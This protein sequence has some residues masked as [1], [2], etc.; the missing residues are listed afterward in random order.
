[1]KKKINMLKSAFLFACILSLICV[2]MTA[3]GAISAKKAPKIN[4]FTANEMNISLGDTVILTWDVEDATSIE[5]LGLEKEQEE[6]LEAKGSLEAWPMATTTYVLIATGEGGTSST[7]LTVNVDVAGDVSLEYFNASDIAVVIGDTV[8]LSWKTS[9]AKEV[10]IIGLE[11]TQEEGLPLCGSIETWPM[12]TTTYVIRVTGKNDEVVSAAI[13]VNIVESLPAVINSFTASKE[14]INEGEIVKLEWDVADAVSVTINSS[15]VKANGSMD[16]TP[17]ETTN[18][19][20][21]AVGT[22][23][24][25][26]SKSITITVLAGPKITSFTATE[27]TVNKGKLVTLTWTTENTTDCVILTDDGIKLPNRPVNGKISVTPNKTRTYTLV[28]YNKEMV[29]AK[30]SITITVR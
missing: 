13:T 29:T 3:F 17:S 27:T 26:V 30:Q 22:D 15:D 8:E 7:S 20:L 5:I 25:A 18:Y 11:K 14:E 1:M 19:E 10:S 24:V 23:G 21:I 6:S 28:A 4:S 2:P 9:N 16:V 12:E